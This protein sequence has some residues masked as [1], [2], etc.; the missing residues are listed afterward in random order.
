M[1]ISF[2]LQEF[3][4]FLTPI[5]ANINFSLNLKESTAMDPHEL[6]K[7]L[8]QRLLRHSRRLCQKRKQENEQRRKKEIVFKE[9]L[10]TFFM[11][12]TTG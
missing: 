7:R 4:T 6:Q 12:G 1:N 10:L 2:G 8:Q 3:T 9:R 11:F 5:M